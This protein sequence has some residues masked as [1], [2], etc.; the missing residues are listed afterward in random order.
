MDIAVKHRNV[1]MYK[2]LLLI[3]PKQYRHQYAQPMVQT[4]DD[5]L[6]GEKS[7]L[8]RIAIWARTLLD[9]P[10]SAAKEHLTN[11]KELEMKVTRNMKILLGG[12]ILLLILAN[13]FSWWEGNLHSRQTSGI[14]KVSLADM[15]DAMQNDHFY[16]TYGN[17]A[18]LFDGKVQSVQ[19]KG[20]VALVTFDT[21]S[22]YSV[23]CQFPYTEKINKGDNISV[24]A[25]GGTAERQPHGVL[26]HDCIMN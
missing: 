24:A 18:L 13:G 10:M 21:T 17:T 22:A 8:G 12:I 11:G 4:F 25:P 14:E 20:K 26:L 6:E 7:Q 16:N 1:G 5:M 3:Y 19:Q 9:L 2:K 15:S 23:T